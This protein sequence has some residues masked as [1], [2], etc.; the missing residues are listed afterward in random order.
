M[1]E[2]IISGISLYF[3]MLDKKFYNMSESSVF[4]ITVTVLR[5][6]VMR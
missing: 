3:L 6:G 2:F 5:V 1:Q 4:I